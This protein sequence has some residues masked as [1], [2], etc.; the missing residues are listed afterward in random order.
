LV[1]VLK[2][3]TFAGLVSV[4]RQWGDAAE[5][6]PEAFRRLGEDALSSLLVATLNIA[7]DTAQREV[8][9]VGGKTDI[10]VEAV[11][12]DRE[13]AAYF[14]EAKIWRG[15]AR[16]AKDVGQ[17]LGYSGSRTTEAMLLYYVKTRLLTSVRSDWSEAMQ[18]RDGFVGFS[19]SGNE[20]V[21]M[22]THP[23]YR[24]QVA[25]TTVFVHLPLA[26]GGNRGR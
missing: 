9:S 24:Q 13:N 19:E 15:Q 14:G 8:F 3:T 18:R 12:G 5:R 25:I 26:P 4:T 2:E 23:T 11:R 7:F 21:V 16:V 10:Y 22:L 1:P 20:D 17:L 6:Y